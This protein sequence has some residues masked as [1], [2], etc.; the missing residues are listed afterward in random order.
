MVTDKLI[1]LEQP[2]WSPHDMFSTGPLVVSASYWQHATIPW[3]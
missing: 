3:C 1:A 2:T